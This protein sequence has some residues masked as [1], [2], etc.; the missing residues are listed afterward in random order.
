VRL[1]RKFRLEETQINEAETGVVSDQQP[2]AFRVKAF[3]LIFAYYQCF[4][5]KKQEQGVF[6]SVYSSVSVTV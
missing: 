5:S 2:F 4:C 6:H 3:V 1:E